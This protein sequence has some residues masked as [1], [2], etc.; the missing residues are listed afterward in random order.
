MGLQKRRLRASWKIGRSSFSV[1]AY[2]HVM[3]MPQLILMPSAAEQTSVHIIQ[4]LEA[5][6]DDR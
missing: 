6:G 3:D 1:S 2:P 5:E 4:A